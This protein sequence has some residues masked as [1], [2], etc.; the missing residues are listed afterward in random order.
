MARRAQMLAS[1]VTD[2]RG[3]LVTALRD[4]STLLTRGRFRS[5]IAL[6]LLDPFNRRQRIAE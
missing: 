5:I 6:L 3:C 4:E 1:F 2:R